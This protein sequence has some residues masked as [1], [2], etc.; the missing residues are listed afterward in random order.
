MAAGVWWEWW[1]RV[2]CPLLQM[3]KLMSEVLS[4]ECG[5]DFVRQ[6]LQL[7]VQGHVI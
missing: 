5:Q 3:F 7:L 2:K 6:E 1:N 4:A